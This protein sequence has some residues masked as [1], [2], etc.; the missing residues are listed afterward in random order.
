M[1]TG[2]NK[3]GMTSSMVAS[4]ILSDIITDRKNPCADVFSSIRSIFQPQLIS[5]V[6]HSVT[7]ILTPTVPRCPHLGCALTYNKE[8]HSW[9]CPCHGSR[10]TESGELIDNPA[11]DD[12]KKMPQR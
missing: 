4:Q 11:T 7:G 2:F 8:E 5:N 12:K 9:D 3:W 10:F 6:F 1:A